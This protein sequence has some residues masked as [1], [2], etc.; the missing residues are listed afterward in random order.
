MSRFST[1]ALLAVL[2]LTLLLMTGCFGKNTAESPGQLQPPAREELVPP[3][4]DPGADT[5][6]AGDRNDEPGAAVPGL[7]PATVNYVVD[8]DTAQITLAGGEEEQVRF[9]GVDT[10]ESTRS[11]NNP[12]GKEAAAFTKKKLEGQQV[13]LELDAE[14]RDRYGRILAYIWLEQP[15]NFSE[16]E[17]RAKLFN[18]VLLLEGYAQVMT[19]P[20]NVN[21]VD[22]F[23]AFQREARDADKGLWGLAREPQGPFAASARSNKYHLPT[24]ESGQKIAPRNLI[25]FK[26][27][28]E[29]LDAGYEPC[30]E[31]NP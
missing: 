22:F 10:P 5:I 8:G 12:S 2:L 28:D 19:V 17:I 3:G 14:E 27:A 15:A 31:C 11:K 18:A 9:I 25:E 30:R 29:A 13:W 24:C 7:L 4:E 6:E 26:T 23:T 16:E 21:Y 20:P 1:L